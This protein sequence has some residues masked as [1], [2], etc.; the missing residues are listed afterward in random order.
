MPHRGRAPP[1]VQPAA[2]LTMRFLDATPPIPSPP[3]SLPTF[4]Q[5]KGIVHHLLSISKVSTQKSWSEIE[6]QCTGALIKS[7]LEAVSFSIP[8]N[9]TNA[10]QRLAMLHSWTAFCNLDL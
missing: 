1:G 10:Q 5:T 9:E 8:H 7:L 6:S 4:G 3:A 2:A